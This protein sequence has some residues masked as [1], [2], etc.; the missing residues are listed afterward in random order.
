MSMYEEYAPRLDDGIHMRMNANSQDVDDITD[1]WIKV[2]EESEEA[3]VAHEVDT[4]LHDPLELTT[5]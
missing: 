3:G 1:D 5:K 4:Y 2:V